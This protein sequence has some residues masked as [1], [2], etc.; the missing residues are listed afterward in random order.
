MFEVSIDMINRT[1]ALYLAFGTEI[2][3][4]QAPQTQVAAF[5]V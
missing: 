3:I 5:R 1:G 4:C 2:R